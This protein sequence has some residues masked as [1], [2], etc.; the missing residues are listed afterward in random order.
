MN[1]N[2]KPMVWLQI[3]S[4]RGPV[5]CE[6]VVYRLL[7]EIQRAAQA[8]GLSVTI[9]ETVPGQSPETLASALIQLQGDK[10]EEFVRAWQGTIQWTGVSPFRPT[11]KRKNWFVG[12]Q[13]LQPPEEKQWPLTDLKFETMR[14][15]GPGGQNV[16]KVSTA[17]RLTHIPTGLVV[18][19]REE[20][21]QH[22][23]RKL[24]LARLAI[25]LRDQSTRARE[26]VRQNL[27]DQHNEL[28]RGNP[29]KTFK[30][31]LE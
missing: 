30:G 25:L 9:L 13:F 17:V 19:A 18:Q 10:V 15:S 22:S 8:Q 2:E 29:V 5:E 4:G 12:I 27:W 28:E 7:P 16:N 6:S 31:A 20:R 14:A 24:A 21:S 26:G 1:A 3:S 11:H 23:N